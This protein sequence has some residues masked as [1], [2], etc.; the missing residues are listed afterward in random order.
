M[1][2]LNSY[3]YYFSLMI[4]LNKYKIDIFIDV[5][6]IYHNNGTLINYKLQMYINTTLLLELSGST[7]DIIFI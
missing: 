5:I 6:I 1:T 2:K 3:I 7:S 4:L